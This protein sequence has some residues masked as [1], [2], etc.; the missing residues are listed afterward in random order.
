MLAFRHR[1]MALAVLII[2]VGIV[3]AYLLARDS[4]PEADAL[5]VATRLDIPLPALSDYAEDTF[6]NGAVADAV[7]ASS[8]VDPADVIPSHVSLATEPDSVTLRVTGHASTGQQAAEFAD[9]AAAALVQELNK[10][11]GVGVFD[12]QRPAAVPDEPDGHAD[13]LAAVL[14]VG[15][16]YG[17]CLAGI[18]LLP[19]RGRVDV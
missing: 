17:V 19:G 1:L 12:V 13:A 9:V 6:R 4:R 7:V 10:D 8:G 15:V 5:V 2:G 11:P 16:V 3:P 18:V 14:A